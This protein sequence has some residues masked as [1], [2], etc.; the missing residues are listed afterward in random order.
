M[1]LNV[2]VLYEL[3]DDNE[4]KITYEAT[5]DKA[6]FVNLTH[7]SFFNLQGQGNGNI[8]DHLLYI[9]AQEYTPVNSGLI[10]T[11]EFESA[12]KDV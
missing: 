4:L 2:K 12:C 10:P 8:N 9:N 7:H 6:T 11:G 3:T 5:T 1:N